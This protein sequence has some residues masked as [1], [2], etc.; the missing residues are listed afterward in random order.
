MVITSGA[1]LVTG[2]GTI[3]GGSIVI[4][5]ATTNTNTAP[6][7]NIFSI[8]DLTIASR[9]TNFAPDAGLPSGLA[10][11]GSGV[12]TLAVSNSYSG[13]TFIHSGTLRLGH[14]MAI[15][16]TSEVF[17]NPGATLD[18]NG[19][20]GTI[21]SLNQTAVSHVTGNNIYG[22]VNIGSVTLTTGSDNNS[23][24]FNGE[25]L[26]NGNLVKRGTGTFT[27]VGGKSFT[28][29][30]TIGNGAV[31]LGTH[32][33]TG[34]PL[35]SAT[36]INIGSASLDGDSTLGFSF[37][38]NS[39]AVPI[40]TASPAGRTATLKFIGDPAGTPGTTLA[41]SI[42]L[43]AR[44]IIVDSAGANTLS[45]A[46]SG[47]GSF[48]TAS[49]AVV[50]AGGPNSFSLNITGNN[51]YTGTTLLTAFATLWGSTTAFGNSTT[52]I[53]VGHTNGPDTPE[54]SSSVGGLTLTRNITVNDS[55]NAVP[56][57]ATIGSRAPTNSGNTTYSGA[58][59]IPGQRRTAILYSQNPGAGVTFSG[60]ISGGTLANV[61]VGN[62]L[63]PGLEFTDSNV[64]LNNTNTYAGGTQVVTGTLNLGTNTVNSGTTILSG[65][66]GTGTLTIGTVGLAGASEP[67]INASG[68]ARTI[69]NPISVGSNFAIRGS[70]AL[71]FS[72][73][74][75]LGGAPRVITT[76]SVSA[77][78]IASTFSGPITGAAGSA[79]VKDGVA[80]LTLSGS[81][82][83]AGPTVVMGG[84]L[85]FGAGE[86]LNG[87]LGI[88]PGAAAVVQPNG[89]RTLVAPSI[90]ID[91]ANG[92]RLDMYD[93][94]LI[95][96]Y[97]GASPIGSI[98][99]LLQSG[100][101]GGAWTGNGIASST[102]AANVGAAT[103]TALG[104]AEATDIFSSFP[105]TFAGQSIDNTSVLVRYTAYGDANLD[106]IV[107]TTDFNLLAA[108]FS[109]TGKRWS[110][111]DF[112]YDGSTDTV[113]FNLLASNF[114]AV[115]PGTPAGASLGALVPEPA[116]MSL[117]LLPLLGARRRRRI[118]RS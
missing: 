56:T 38:M 85:S 76:S 10:K 67:T 22:T 97:T 51:T 77:G 57:F 15:P 4:G 72:G 62:S 90:S 59:S 20:S 35:A 17:V 108:N 43:G 19:N 11:A 70:N 3:S 82:S 112:N 8:A 111:A 102:A 54:L 26:G 46:I 68:G 113:D 86:K 103:K 107:D 104:V 24:T 95:V 65:P 47:T 42:T 61:Q 73:P 88:G 96:D 45:G 16:A 78:P 49:S 27:L 114:A 64:T 53:G 83:Y 5:T 21:G 12:L 1:L 106:G 66:V 44:G 33:T 29:T 48:M 115:V 98:V 80:T 93:N 105:A 7:F 117:V 69:S 55:L 18:M 28:G 92:A 50:L 75:D 101:N 110:Q 63:G 87:L 36:R 2:A 32:I 109:G 91:A 9:I 34:T 60:V 41:S 58:I 79:L 94:E 23:T 99:A 40:T 89:S 116:S 100:Y 25:I 37:G 14:P 30:L 71:T 74:M 6:T 31:V 52:A 13:P 84:T 81:N 118:T 39:F